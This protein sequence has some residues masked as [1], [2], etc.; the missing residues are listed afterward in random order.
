MTSAVNFPSV[1]TEWR[2]MASAPATGPSPAIG[3]KMAM[4]ST[5]SGKARI[6]LSS[7]RMTFETKPLDTF[8]A[9]K[10]P[11]GRE[12]MAPMTVPTQASWSDSTMPL[13]AVGR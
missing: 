5:I 9:P 6:A 8:F 4:A 7:W 10:N 11:N 2:P 12:M 13:I 3:M 1:P